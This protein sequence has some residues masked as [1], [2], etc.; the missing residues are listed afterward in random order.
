MN[1]SM[2]AALEMTRLIFQCVTAVVSFMIV[3][4]PVLIGR[5]IVKGK[6]RRTQEARR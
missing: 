3:V 2:V 6:R 5:N 1:Q 4:I